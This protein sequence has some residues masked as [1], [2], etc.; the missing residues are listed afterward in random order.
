MAALINALDS[1]THTHTPMQIGEKGH[2][3]YAWSND[4]QE[5]FFN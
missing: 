1:Y 5:K 4:L 2:A 3:E